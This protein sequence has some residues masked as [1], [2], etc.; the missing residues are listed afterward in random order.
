MVD[1][2]KDHFA[3]WAKYHPRPIGLNWETFAERLVGVN[4]DKN[5]VYK[6]DEVVKVEDN[7]GTPNERTLYEYDNA[8]GGIVFGDP[9]VPVRINVN[10]WSNLETYDG[11]ASRTIPSYTGAPSDDNVMYYDIATT[12]WKVADAS[13]IHDHSGVYSPIGH[14]HDDDYV[15]VIGGDSMQGPFTVSTDNVEITLGNLTLPA[16]NIIVTV[17]DITVT[18]GDLNMTNGHIY[19]YSG[20][21]Y[22]GYIIAGFAG[23]P[24]ADIHANASIL[25]EY[26]GGGYKLEDSGNINRSVLYATTALGLTVGSSSLN[27]RIETVGTEL[28][29][30]TIAGDF[31]VPKQ[32]F[33]HATPATGTVMV[34]TADNDW[35]SEDVQQITLA[36][37][38]QMSANTSIDIYSDAAYRNLI[39]ASA[40][41]LVLGDEALSFQAYSAGPYRFHD[42]NVR[43][44]N[45][46]AFVINKYSG[47]AIIALYI[48]GSDNLRLGDS[49]DRLLTYVYAD[50]LYL[51]VTPVGSNVEIIGGHAYFDNNYGVR[52]F[53]SSDAG[54]Y[55]LIKLN[56][57]NETEIANTTYPVRIYG[58][59]TRPQYNDADLCLYSDLG[60][61]GGPWLPLSA[62]SGYPLTG[63]LY[64]ET[65]ST[66]QIRLAEGGAANSYSQLY[67]TAAE[68]NIKKIEPTTARIRLSPVPSDGLST[69]QVDMFRYTTTAGTRQIVIYKGDG[70][71]TEQHTFNAGT[72]DVTLCQ[73]DGGLKMHANSEGISLFGTAMASVAAGEVNIGYSGANLLRVRTN[74]GYVDFGAVSSLAV[75]FETGSDDFIF[76]KPVAAEGAVSDYNGGTPIRIGEVITGTLVIGTTTVPINLRGSATRPQYKGADLALFAD[77]PGGANNIVM[78][79]EVELQG[80]SFAGTPYLLA[81]RN[82]SDTAIY[83]AVAANFDTWIYGDEIKIMPLGDLVLDTGDDIYLD[84]AGGDVFL[85]SGT[86]FKVWTGSAYRAAVWVD[87]GVIVFGDGVPG[88]ELRGS[89]IVLDSGDNI[90]AEPAAG[91]EF[92]VEGSGDLIALNEIEA[93]GK[94]RAKYNVGFY[95]TDST[96]GD[97]KVAMCGAVDILEIG[98]SANATTWLQ[99]Q[100]DIICKDPLVCDST[101]TMQNN[102]NFRIDNSGGTPVGLMVLTSGN[103]FRVGNSSYKTL[104]LGISS[105]SSDPST[106]DFGS[107]QWGVHKNT[108]SGTVYFVY[109]DNNTI[110]KVALA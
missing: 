5:V 14:D 82:S 9:Q 25:I 110:K 55:S 32:S 21:I 93:L 96:L 31:N 22:G 46:Q 97:V 2:I 56:S 44:D 101:I 30:N 38:L 109:N 36:Q 89:P 74:G 16:G 37:D 40:G 65:T 100:D 42:G 53:N 80:K 11:A 57:D 103:L 62:G 8:F 88:I 49:T 77:I 20:R 54:P 47:D 79:N 3:D 85:T 7:S 43:I 4:D 68:F 86:S 83:G 67:D 95:T 71:A 12:E 108:S 17:G 64:I 92:R 98:D 60:G 94:I 48:D 23:T 39:G 33:D 45:D 106:S 105:S 63:N 66:P 91:K 27:T 51:D 41:D 59:E 28:I 99:S 76:N 29:F 73:T 26:G 24:E 35:E 69:S 81:K 34:L 19:A 78:D 75:L 52:G 6:N 15:N 102:T 58:S 87:T 72:G 1:F 84:P 61:V 13:T 10:A 18:A 104:M 107:G 50:D 70:T 90:V